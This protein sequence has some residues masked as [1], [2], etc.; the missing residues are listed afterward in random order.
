[1][2]IV[3]EIVGH[4]GQRRPYAQ[5]K[6]SEFVQAGIGNPSIWDDLAAQNLLGIER[7]AE[8]FDT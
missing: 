7:F 4:L 5:E 6:Y 1:V 3:D 2:S 8:D